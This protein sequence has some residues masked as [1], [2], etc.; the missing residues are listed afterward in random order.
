MNAMRSATALA[1]TV[2]FASTGAEALAAG[3]PPPEWAATSFPAVDGDTLLVGA[4]AIGFAKK[5]HFQLI[6][7]SLT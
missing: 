4:A 3:Q 6:A 2:A 7:Y 1:L 5:P